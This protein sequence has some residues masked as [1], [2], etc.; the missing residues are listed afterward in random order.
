MLNSWFGSKSRHSQTTPQS[1]P[2]VSL[3][4]TESQSTLE[5]PRT[6]DTV[7]SSQSAIPLAE[8]H[9][10]I[11][12]PSV[13]APTASLS[14]TQRAPDTLRTSDELRSI[15]PALEEKAKIST[16]GRNDKADG[17]QSLFTPHDAILAEVFGRP[18][19]EPT[20]TDLNTTSPHSHRPPPE[21][22]LITTST[23]PLPPSTQTAP[24]S[25][26][27]PA[28]PP[29]TTGPSITLYDPFS[30]SKLGEYH[31][32]TVLP[33][34]G[35]PKLWTHLERVLELQAEVAGMHAD[36]EGVGVARGTGAGR[37]GEG[38]GLG[39]G[40][41]IGGA[42]GEPSGKAGPRKGRMRRGET[43]PIGDDDEPEP[44]T[45]SGGGGTTDTS[46]EHSDGDEADD[47]EE[48]ED[49]HGFGKRRRDE[50]FARLAEQ[51]AERKEAIGG[52][53]NKVRTY[54]RPPYFLL[55]PNTSHKC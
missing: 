48:E 18:A 23:S 42:V 16:T 8:V 17:T 44:V 15:E 6:P 31:P 2:P 34:T 29:N 52:I 9:A 41:G 19:N 50:E 43:M 12:D 10:H 49:I 51:F 7:T 37:G 54:S 47:E 25:S 22:S 46:T 32:T 28:A 33:T 45:A 20:N 24:T 55:Y 3:A 26:L 5:P 1:Q 11:N 4:D 21:A 39:F 13:Y 36:M 27:P 53:M 35:D 14:L 40:V 38:V 30:G